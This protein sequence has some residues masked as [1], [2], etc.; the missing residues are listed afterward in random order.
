MLKE[1]ILSTIIKIKRNI[2]PP[3]RQSSKRKKIKNK[4][5]YV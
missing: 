3:K 5:V 1:L 4:K 2:S